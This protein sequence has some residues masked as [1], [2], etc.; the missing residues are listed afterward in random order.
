MRGVVFIAAAAVVFMISIGSCTL[1]LVVV[2]SPDGQYQNCVYAVELQFQTTPQKFSF[3]DKISC[4]SFVNTLRAIGAFVII[5]CI[6]TGVSTIAVALHLAGVLTLRLPLYIGALA[7]VVFTVGAFGLMVNTVTGTFCGNEELNTSLH[8]SG[9]FACMIAASIVAVGAGVTVVVKRLNGYAIALYPLTFILCVGCCLIP[10]I[11]GELNGV[12]VDITLFNIQGYIVAQKIKLQDVPCD[13]YRSAYSAVA[14]F[15]IL[16]CIAVGLMLVVEMYGIVRS[17]ASRKA[18][19]I[20]TLVAVL[21]SALATALQV[22]GF[23]TAFCSNDGGEA[24]SKSG[25]LAGGFACS[26]LVLVVTSAI[27]FL[28]RRSIAPAGAVYTSVDDQSVRTADPKYD[29]L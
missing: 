4:S 29:A 7:S 10:P 14:A 20:V 15:I 19:T 18:T 23:V 12:T 6:A 22:Y 26:V 25:H 13:Q 9:G 8:L 21:F 27:A 3:G 16:T 11:S 17:I 1:P 2:E 24:F 28:T 5:A